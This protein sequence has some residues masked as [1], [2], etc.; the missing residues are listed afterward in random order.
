MDANIIQYFFTQGPF[1]V[2]FVLLLIWVMRKN[3]Q[4]EHEYKKEIQINREESLERESRLHQIMDKF[5]SK[6]DLIIDE[7]RD[8]KNK[9]KE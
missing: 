5:T 2:L 7:L 9:F 1:A 3:D 6:Y 4:R 8:I